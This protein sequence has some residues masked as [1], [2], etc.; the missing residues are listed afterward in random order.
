MAHNSPLATIY[1][2][3]SHGEFFLYA[4]EN[5]LRQHAEK[6]GAGGK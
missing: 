2:T 1:L 5:N 6:V 3:V 4:Q